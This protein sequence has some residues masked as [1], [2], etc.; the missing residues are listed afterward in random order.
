[1]ID[2]KAVH[3]TESFPMKKIETVSC[4][5]HISHLLCQKKK[6]K[7]KW[8]FP[9]GYRME[10]KVFKGNGSELYRCGV[11]CGVK[12]DIKFKSL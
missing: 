12:N 6:R 10:K 11:D 1:M 3:L 5:K 8:E 2:I 4:Q 7:K 9:L